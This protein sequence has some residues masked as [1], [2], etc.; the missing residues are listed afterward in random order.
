VG[1]GSAISTGA[2]TSTA[3][4]QAATADEW[5]RHALRRQSVLQVAMYERDRH[6]ALTDGRC[7]ALDR[8]VPHVPGREEPRYVRFQIIRAAMYRDDL[9]AEY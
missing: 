1:R 5:C 8:V 3:N 7:A 4:R 6:R 9:I 2:V